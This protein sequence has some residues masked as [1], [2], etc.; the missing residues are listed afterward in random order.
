LG[1]SSVIVVSCHK[2]VCTR[3]H[4]RAYDSAAT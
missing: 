3:L 4:N 2:L 1:T